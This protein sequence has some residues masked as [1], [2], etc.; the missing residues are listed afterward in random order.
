MTLMERLETKYEPEPMSGCWIWTA[1]VAGH[2]YGYVWHE[3]RMRRAHAVVYEHL[4][5]PV[6]EGKELDH[7]CRVRR[8]VNPDHLRPVT[9]RENIQASPLVGRMPGSH[10]IGGWR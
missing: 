1:G 9:H 3:G 2:G 8:C 4:V 6:P 10:P 7:R 5:G